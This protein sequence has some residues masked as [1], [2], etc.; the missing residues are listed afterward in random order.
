LILQLL[1]KGLEELIK[2]AHTVCCVDDH[3]TSQYVCGS[4]RFA[5]RVHPPK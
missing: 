4:A 2:H 5:C 3:A 1:L